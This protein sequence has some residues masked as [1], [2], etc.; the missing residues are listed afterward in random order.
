MYGHIARGHD[1][2]HANSRHVLG[3]QQ[4][5]VIADVALGIDGRNLFL[6]TDRGV[7]RLALQ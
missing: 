3:N 2:G 6:A 4:T 5:S 1:G 7:A